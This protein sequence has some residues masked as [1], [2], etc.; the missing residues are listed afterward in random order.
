MEL[1]VRD[2]DAGG[3]RPSVRSAASVVPCVIVM[4][5]FDRQVRLGFGA[6]LRG[7]VD[8]SSLGVVV[9]HAIIAEPEHVLGWCGTLKLSNRNSEYI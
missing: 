2:V 8:P 3:R 1:T 9:N 5:V 7:D 6:G 4:S